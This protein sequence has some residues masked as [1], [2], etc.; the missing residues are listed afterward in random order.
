MARTENRPSTHRPV[1]RTDLPPG[2]SDILTSL[3]ERRARAASARLAHD[4]ATGLGRDVAMMPAPE[5]RANF[6]VLHTPET[7]S[8]LVEMG[9]LS[10][11][12]EEAALNDPAHRSR[13]AEAITRAVSDWFAGARDA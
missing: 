9:F 8:V 13:I 7:P 4:V 10:N 3:A 12:E 6:T 5:R 2:V 1:P 11:P